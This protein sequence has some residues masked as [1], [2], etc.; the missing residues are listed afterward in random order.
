MWELL[1]N[2]RLVCFGPANR[3]GWYKTQIVQ[4]RAPDSQTY[5]TYLS[6]V[7]VSEEPPARDRKMPVNCVS[8]A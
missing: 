2:P 5:R 3:L 8:R 1:L 7:C 6:N 4:G